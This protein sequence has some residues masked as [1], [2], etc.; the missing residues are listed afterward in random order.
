MC[1]LSKSR[2]GPKTQ[3]F[4]TVA[5][6]LGRRPLTYKDPSDSVR[7]NVSDHVVFSEYGVV[8]CIRRCKPPGID[9][10]TCMT[11][12]GIPRLHDMLPISFW[13]RRGDHSL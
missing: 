8:N 13:M 3:H 4:C 2:Q 12:F 6:I 5:H 7:S 1:K 9:P 11:M 10:I